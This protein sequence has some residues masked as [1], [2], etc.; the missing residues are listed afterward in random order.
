M[1]IAEHALYDKDINEVLLLIG[2][3]LFKE[4]MEKSPF[5]P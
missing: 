2:I 4:K 1:N 3:F 5:G